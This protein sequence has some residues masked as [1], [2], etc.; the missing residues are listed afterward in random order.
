MLMQAQPNHK[1]APLPP[2]E[3]PREPTTDER[4]A[5]RAYLQRTEVRLSTLHRIAIAFVSGAGLLI[6]FPIFLKDEVT[7]IL[8]VFVEFGVRGLPSLNATDTPIAGIMVLALAFPFL[9]TSLIPLYGMYLLLKDIVHFYFTI[10]TPGFPGSLFTPS[11]VLSGI[12]FSPDESEEMKRR[13]YAYQYNPNAINFMIPFSAEKRAVYLEETLRNT[14]GEVIPKSRQWE[15]LQA[16]GVLPRDANRELVEHFNVGFGLARTLDRRLVEE[17]ATTE[18]SMVRHVLYL[19]RLVIRYVGTLISFIWTTLVS[20]FMIP[21]IQEPQVPTFLYM[22]ITYVIWA[23]FVLPFIRLP[24]HW[25]YR[26]RHGQVDKRHIDRQM[27]VFEERVAPY[28]Y[29]A[30]VSSLIGL[31]CAVLIYT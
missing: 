10:Y 19:R 11:F 22:A 18:A 8:R 27:M 13:V 12:T 4:N 5:M 3:E 16:E 30:I 24:V 9:L 17:V 28:I 7:A 1:E 6:L 2:I 29:G 26:H 14:N 20:F 23:A 31:V 15:H 25:I 21:F